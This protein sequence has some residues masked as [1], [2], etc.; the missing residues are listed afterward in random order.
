M[1]TP[2]IR[3]Q[4]VIVSEEVQLQSTYDQVEWKSLTTSKEFELELDIA[5]GELPLH[6]VSE[7]EQALQGKDATKISTLLPTQT[8]SRPLTSPSSIPSALS[9]PI[10]S[11]ALYYND[12]LPIFQRY[13][14][15]RDIW[16]KAQP[17]GATLTNDLYRKAMGLQRRFKPASFKWCLEF[18]QMG[19]R[20][21]TPTGGRD[22]TKEEMMAYLDWDKPRLLVL[23]LR[24]HMK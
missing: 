22:W 11:Q 6:P 7:S 8:V 19:K 23:K 9:N 24:W 1:N 20:C 15:A 10:G 21:I 14:A 18:K 3:W 2:R 4:P 16:Y 17:P 12:S 13:V 5:L